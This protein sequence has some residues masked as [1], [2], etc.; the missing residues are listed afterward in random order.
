[1]FVVSS[2][3]QPVPI[4]LKPINPILRKL[5]VPCFGVLIIRILLSIGYDIRVSISET[6]NSVERMSDPGEDPAEKAAEKAE[7][8]KAKAP[9]VGIEEWRAQLLLS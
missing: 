1:M 6:P 5:G 8:A 4:T 2:P 3:T 7:K 9:G